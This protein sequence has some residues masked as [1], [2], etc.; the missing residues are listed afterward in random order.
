MSENSLL[1]NSCQF[2]LNIH[3]FIKQLGH[4]IMNIIL[5]HGS[6]HGAWCWHKVIPELEALGHQVYAPDLPAHGRNWRF[7]R[8]RT[9]LKQLANAVCTVIDSLNAPALIVAH[10]RYGIVASTVAEMRHN[11]LTGTVYLAAYMLKNG[12][13]AATF[14]ARDTDSMLTPHVNINKVMMTDSLDEVAYQPYLYADCAA[15]DV[16]LA[17]TLLSAGPLLPAIARLK[18]SDAKYGTVPR[19]YIELTQDKAV[20]PMLQKQ[21]IAATLCKTVTTLEASH[22]AYFSCPDK[23]AAV[24]DKISR[25]K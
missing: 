21:M 10:S 5:I 2:I 23:L 3:S 18:L 8:G 20:S 22:S 9:T 25:N 24:L 17:K 4:A 11:K 13:R 19:H 6:W 7:M 14:F 1:H 12:Q 15:S 16:A